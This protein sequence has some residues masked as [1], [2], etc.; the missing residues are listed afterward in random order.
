M[1]CRPVTVAVVILLSVVP[2]HQGELPFRDHQTVLIP[3][4]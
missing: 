1:Q 4:D 3:A 2:G